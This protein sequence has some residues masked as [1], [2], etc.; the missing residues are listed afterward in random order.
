MWTFPYFW[1]CIENESVEVFCKDV[2]GNSI[3]ICKENQFKDIFV[4]YGV[5]F[6]DFP[7]GGWPCRYR[8]ENASVKKMFK[9]FSFGYTFL[10]C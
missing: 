1:G 3:T 5:M 8:V 7:Y 4:G 6:E 9:V 10:F 2:W